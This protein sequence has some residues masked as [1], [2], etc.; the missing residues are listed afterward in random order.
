[1]TK[2]PFDPRPIAESIRANSA[3]IG[4]RRI[5]WAEFSARQC[6]AWDRATLGEPNVMGSACDRR[7]MAVK[8]LLTR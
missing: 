4:A 3:D 8:S 6:A 1:M 2:L 7:M 5:T